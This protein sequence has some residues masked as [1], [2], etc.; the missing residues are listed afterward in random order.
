MQ[1][2]KKKTVLISILTFLFLVS[3]SLTF[4]PQNAS[5][6]TKTNNIAD[7][8]ISQLNE[9]E[10]QTELDYIYNNIIVL[11]D[12]GAAVEVNEEKAKE[13]YGYVPEAFQTLQSEIDRND[14]NNTSTRAVGDNYDNLTD[15]FYSE[16]TKDYGELLSTNTLATLMNLVKEKN[17][18][19]ITK[20]L[21]GIGVKGNLA[22]IAATMV[23]K[24]TQCTA[25]YG[26]L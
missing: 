10:I 14:A 7:Q 1:K 12:N 4:L 26:Q 25:K 18:P 5:A 21:L 11:D 3:T 23:A 20:K 2:I 22:G 9:E 19:G 8:D 13:R 16:M 15:C 6:N 24:D 17:V